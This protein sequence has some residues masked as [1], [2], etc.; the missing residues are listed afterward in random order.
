MAPFQLGESATA[1]YELRQQVD[2]L[3]ERINVACEEERRSGDDRRNGFR[4]NTDRRLAMNLAKA[5]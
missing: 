4:A 1:L 2:T 3:R 5:S